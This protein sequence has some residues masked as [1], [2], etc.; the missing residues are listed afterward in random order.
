MAEK[1]R[2]RVE[3][4]AVLS[5]ITRKGMPQV[6]EVEI[7]DASFFQCVLERALDFSVIKSCSIIMKNMA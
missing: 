7:A 4:Y 6:M 5:Q 3:I 1:I 2:N